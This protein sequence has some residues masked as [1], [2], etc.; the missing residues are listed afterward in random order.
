MLKAFHMN[1]IDEIWIGQNKEEVREAYKVNED[2][3]QIDEDEFYELTSKAVLVT[4]ILNPNDGTTS[5][6]QEELIKAKKDY[7]EPFSICCDAAYA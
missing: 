6:L 1:D 7:S 4:V 5:T 3:C 2:D